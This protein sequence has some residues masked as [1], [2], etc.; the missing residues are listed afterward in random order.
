MGRHT[1]LR[2]QEQCAHVME[3][4]AGLKLALLKLQLFSF[5]LDK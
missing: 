2:Y 4:A 1:G 5:L 3:F